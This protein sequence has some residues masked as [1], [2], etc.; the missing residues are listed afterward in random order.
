MTKNT[1]RQLIIGIAG[2][3]CSGKNVA[4]DFFIERNFGILDCDKIVHTLL[5]QNCEKINQLF[6]AKA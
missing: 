6:D 1:S 3:S 4:S 2:T 5:E